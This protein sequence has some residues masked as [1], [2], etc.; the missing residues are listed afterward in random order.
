MGLHIF[1]SETT[2]PCTVSVKKIPISSSGHIVHCAFC[3]LLFVLFHLAWTSFLVCLDCKLS[4]FQPKAIW[5]KHRLRKKEN[6][7]KK[8]TK[9]YILCKME[10]HNCFGST[11][12]PMVIS[13]DYDTHL[14]WEFVHSRTEYTLVDTLFCKHPSIRSSPLIFVTKLILM[15]LQHIAPIA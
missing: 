1:R 3:F 15:I 5:P 11:W 6:Q 8:E 4:Q 12:R 9:F 13:S 14:M 7:Q 2:S 10:I